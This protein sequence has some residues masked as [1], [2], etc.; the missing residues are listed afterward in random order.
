MELPKR[1][2]LERIL[3]IGI[4]KEH[5]RMLVNEYGDRVRLDFIDDNKKQRNH[6]RNI[7]AYDKIWNMVKFSKHTSHVAYRHHPRYLMLQGGISGIRL[8]LNSE[9]G[10]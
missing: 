8:I 1:L 9:Y 7:E 4:R 10:E 3:I 6:V 2:P 5:S